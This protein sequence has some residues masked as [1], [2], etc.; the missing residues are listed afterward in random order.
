VIRKLSFS[1]IYLIF[2][3]IQVGFAQEVTKLYEVPTYTGEP[4][5]VRIKYIPH[6]P[7]VDVIHIDFWTINS[8]NKPFI[9]H[10]FM[11]EE[12]PVILALFAYQMGELIQVRFR[13]DYK[14]GLSQGISE[15]KL[16]VTDKNGEQIFFTFRWQGQELESVLVMPAS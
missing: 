10:R 9:D 11:S 14:P 2:L 13:T 4:V 5:F 16:T 3:S 15:K 8:N 1:V 6:E 7:A 12:G